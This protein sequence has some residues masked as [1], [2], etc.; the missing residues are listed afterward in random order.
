MEQLKAALVAEAVAALRS[1]YEEKL[2]G[3]TTER[4]RLREEV[5][6][7]RPKA[8]AYVR[9]MAAAGQPVPDEAAHRRHIS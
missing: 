2:A 8:E 5:G 6:K 7:L 1:E 3:L 9:M 4:D